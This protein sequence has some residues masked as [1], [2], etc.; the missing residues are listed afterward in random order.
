MSGSTEQNKVPAAGKNKHSYRLLC[1]ILTF[2]VSISTLSS[3][4]LDLTFKR[5]VFV[6]KKNPYKFI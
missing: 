4:G 6:Q 1:C 2:F 5:P 3:F